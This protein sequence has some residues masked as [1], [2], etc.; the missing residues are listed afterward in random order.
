MPFNDIEIS[1]N[2]L[3]KTLSALTDG[4]CIVDAKQPRHP[5]LYV[6][7]AFEAMSGF[8][9]EETLGEDYFF[10]NSTQTKE[11]ELDTISSAF[12]YGQCCHVVMR[13]KRK[14][15]ELFW[16]D[17]TLSAI[18]DKEG[19]VCYFISVQKD[20]SDEIE[21]Q[22][23]IAEQI[24]ALEDAKRRLEGLARTD[25]LTGL[26]N[27]RYFEL[28][29]P[30]QYSIAK[31]NDDCLTAFMI[32][33][34]HFKH[35]NDHYGHIS[36]DKCLKQV[37]Q[38]LGHVFQRT[39]DF[40]ARFGGE[41]FIIYSV[42]LSELQAQVSARNLLEYMKDLKI[43]HEKSELSYVTVSI[44]IASAL[45]EQPMGPNELIERADKAMYLAKSSGR[46]KAVVY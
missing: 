39:S 19:N 8:S 4:V 37:A 41:E 28:Q 30:T 43:P 5:I 16:S 25:S 11:V 1:K 12:T 13:N 31:R 9:L 24:S 21:T 2:L 42:G 36:G 6:N 17:T 27:K 14:S 3:D 10:L 26:Y 29:Y 20:I 45:W 46:N 18:P 40:V 34:D 44:G 22:K 23:V 35:Y 38:A 32:D 7:P 33:V 15:G